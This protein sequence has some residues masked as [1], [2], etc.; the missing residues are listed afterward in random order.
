MFL[1]L[2]EDLESSGLEPSRYSKCSSCKF[3]AECD[4]DSEGIWLVIVCVCVC[5]LVYM[6]YEETDFYNEMC[7][8]LVLQCKHGL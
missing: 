1:C 7:I 2:C 5:V 3:G 6:I 8:T 4:E